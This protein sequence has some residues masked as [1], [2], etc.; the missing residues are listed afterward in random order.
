[1]DT[2]N[3]YYSLWLEKKESALRRSILDYYKDCWFFPGCVIK[4]VV[5]CVRYMDGSEQY[6]I[7]G[8]VILTAPKFKN[9]L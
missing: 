1:M 2:I 5:H 7:E 3:D 8:D 6:S 4:E 9:T